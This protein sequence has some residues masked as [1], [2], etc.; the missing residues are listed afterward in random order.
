MGADRVTVYPILYFAANAYAVVPMKGKNAITPMVL[1]PNVARGGDPLGQRGSV[2]I[3][4][5]HA[6]VI[7]QDA[8][9]ARAEVG[10]SDLL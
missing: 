9:M 8:W 3:K 5:Y 10:C 6:C 4:F 7:L 2:G 1:N